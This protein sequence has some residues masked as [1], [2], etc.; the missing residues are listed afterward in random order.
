MIAPGERVLAA[1]SGGGDSV[2]LA[3]A[4]RESGVETGICAIDHGLR[5]GASAEVEQVRLLASRLGVWFATRR[6]RVDPAGRG[7]E[8]AAR[9]AR[10]AAIEEIR[11]T[12]KFD[13]IATGHTRTDQAETVL[14]RLVRGAGLRGLSGIPP[15]RARVVRPL[16]DLSR[17]QLRAFL[18]ERGEPWVE[19]PHNQDLRFARVRLRQKVWPALLAMNPR[20]EEALA[21]LADRLRADADRLDAIG[22]PE[23]DALALARKIGLDPDARAVA[24]MVRALAAGRDPLRE[25]YG[26]LPGGKPRGRA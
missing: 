14:L 4:L 15:V 24:R 17:D 3:L 18:R 5:P 25:A 9:R 6:V 26:R 12:G 13:R 1:V 21:G 22:S 20:L 23:R 8:D 2:A 16:I 10:Y 19:D 7:L 11:A